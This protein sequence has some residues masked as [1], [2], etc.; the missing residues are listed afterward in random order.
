MAGSK[1]EWG[2]GCPR[3]VC[4]SDVQYTLIWGY[5]T[6]LR[7]PTSSLRLMKQKMGMLQR[8]VATPSAQVG[9]PG[10]RGVLSLQQTSVKTRG[11]RR[12]VRLN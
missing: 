6:E 11:S 1:S 10:T 8:W 12:G 3:R 2:A 9:L 4:L 7:S 5:L